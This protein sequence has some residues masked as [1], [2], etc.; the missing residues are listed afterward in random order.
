VKALTVFHGEGTNRLASRWLK[1]G[2]RHVFVAVCL[3][4]P[5]APAHS[6][7]LRLDWQTGEVAVELVAGATFDL[8]G[9]YRDAGFTVVETETRDGEQGWCPLDVISCVGLAKMILGIRA[10]F[11]LT[12]FSLF[13]WL[14]R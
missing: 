7:W 13:R 6:C 9:H 1:P 4:D 11:V 5:A 12:P 14:D 10:P 2:F 8:A 3:E